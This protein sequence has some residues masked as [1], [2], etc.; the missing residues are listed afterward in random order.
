M[1][2]QLFETIYNGCNSIAENAYLESP[3]DTELK[4]PMLMEEIYFECNV[5][6]L[7]EQ[8]LREMAQEPVNDDNDIDEYGKKRLGQYKDQRY[9]GTLNNPN[10]SE[11]EFKDEVDGEIKLAKRRNGEFEIIRVFNDN[12]KETVGY[13]TYCKQAVDFIL[14]ITV[15]RTAENFIKK[16]GGVS[17]IDEMEKFIENSFKDGIKTIHW[18]CYEDN[19]IKDV[20]NKRFLKYNPEIYKDK[21]GVITY[22]LNKENIPTK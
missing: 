18:T 1:T 12:N 10:Q 3:L 4:P 22:I 16:K 11:E 2:N 21:Y 9:V 5:K 15:F 8:V 17:V 7:F 19:P 6:P 13:I 14:N 20:Y